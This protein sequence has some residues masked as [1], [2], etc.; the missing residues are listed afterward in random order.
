MLGKTA[1]AILASHVISY[2]GIIKVI[3]ITT[4]SVNRHR[5]QKDRHWK[6]FLQLVPLFPIHFGNGSFAHANRAQRQLSWQNK[7]GRKYYWLGGSLGRVW[8][9]ST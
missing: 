2:T 6:G 4:L 1:A 9:K 7:K 8:W 3:G 5:G